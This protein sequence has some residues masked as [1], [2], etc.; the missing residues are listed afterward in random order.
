MVRSDYRRRGRCRRSPARSASTSAF[1]FVGRAAEL[2][3]LRALVPRA[4]GEGRRVVA[5]RRR[6]RLRQEPA[7]ARVR[8]RGGRATARSSSTAPAT[9]SCARR[10]ARSSRRSTSSSRVLDP[11]EL[12]AALGPAAASWR[13]SC[14]TCATRV[15]ELPAPVAADP[16]TERHRLH[17]AVADL[18]DGAGRERPRAA[19]ARGRPLGRRADARC[20]CATSRARAAS[21]RLLLLATFRDTEADVPAALAETLADLRRSDDVVRLRLAGLS[22]DEV[23][24]FVRRAAGGERRPR[25]SWRA[26]IARPD[27]RQRVP[28]SASCGARSSRRG[29]VEVG[30]GAVRLTPPARRARQPRR[31]CARSSASGSR[32]SRPATARPARARRRRPAPSS[33]STSLRARRRRWPTPSCSRALD[34]AVAQRHDRGAPVARARLPVHARAR[35]ARALRPALAALRRAELHLRVGE[36]LEAAGGALGPRAR[37]PRAPLRRRRAVRRRASARSS[38]TC[39]PRA[40]PPPRSPSTRRRRGCARAL[41][42]GIDDP[43]ERAEL[44]LELGDGAAPRRARGRRARGVRRGGRDRPRARRRRAARARRDRLRGRVLAPGDHRP[45]R[46]RAARGGGRRA[47]R[48]ADSQLRVGVLGGLARALDVPGRARARRRRARRAR[49]R[50]RGGSATAPALADGARA[51]ATG[52]AG[53]RSLEEILEMLTEARDLGEEL[54]DIEIRAE[55]MDW[56]VS[57]LVA[58]VRPRRGAR[59]RSPPCAR[60]AERTRAAV[61]APR[62]RALR[63]GDRALRR[64]GSTTPRRWPQ[65][66]HEWSRLLTGRDASGVYGIQMFGIRREQGRLAELAPVDPG[67]R[68]RRRARRRLAARA[69]R[70]ARRARDGGRGAARARARRAPTGSTRF[71]DV[72][73]ARLARPTSTDA[74]RGARRRGDGRARSTRSSRRSRARNVMIGHLVACYGAADRYLGMLAATL[75]ECGARRVRTSSARSTLNRRDGRADLGRAHRLRVRALLLRARRRRARPRGG[76]ARRGGGARR[77]DRDAGAARAGS[78]AL[79]RAAPARGA[80]RTGSRR[81]RSQIL[82]LVAEG[83]SNREIG[84]ALFISEHTAANHIRSILRKTGCANRTEAASYAHRH[85]LVERLSRR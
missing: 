15:G 29:A 54:G 17:T 49:S 68:R 13:G 82:G 73:V 3:T 59:A 9:R 78:R 50:W 16:D 10:T 55:A 44:L 21:A 14:P 36:A 63:L 24:E 57:A 31:A 4:D 53:R 85:G 81:A 48:R 25:P 30:G 43:A 32:G 37:R 6:G 8:R 18:L 19:R 84:G 7:R 34:E 26:A 40:P 74:A 22:G 83:L 2:A 47:R 5:G 58:L 71:R 79:G 35:A 11:D 27:R 61:H 46:G 66:S 76:A 42:L 65:R 62:R 70:A 45:G 64:A 12:R 51:R 72:A 67:A 69:R 23:A 20:C 1:P 39:S 28:A 77:A 41:E 80:A 75:G 52:R 33:S 56:R 60:L 38:T